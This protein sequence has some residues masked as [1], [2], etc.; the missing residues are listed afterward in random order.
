MLPCY[1]SRI[2]QFSVDRRKNVMD[3][4]LPYLLLSTTLDQKRSMIGMFSSIP[5]NQLQEAVALIN[6]YSQTNQPSN[7]ELIKYVKEL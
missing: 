6:S 7:H 4:V 1:T 2:G 5:D 3:A